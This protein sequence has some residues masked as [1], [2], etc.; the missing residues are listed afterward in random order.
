MHS[1]PFR[2]LTAR[3]LVLPQENI[4]TDQIIPARFLTTTAREGLGR[5]AFHDW[6]A[7]DPD[8]VFDHVEADDRRILVAGA[9]FGCGSSREHAPWALHDLGVRAV[10][11][12]RVADIF[13]ANALENG[14]LPVEVDE[15]TWR[16]LAEHDGETVTVDL[17]ACELRFANHVTSF[18]VEPFARRRLLDGADTLSWLLGR[19]PQIETYEQR[20]AA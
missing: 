2:T 3:T 14:L 6:R 19:L 15:A 7:V 5:F 13:K 8:S 9:N 4:D 1:A 18:D 10:I 16:R 12:T 11:S 17:E 20:R